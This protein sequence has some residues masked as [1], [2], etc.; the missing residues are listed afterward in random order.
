VV[1][2]QSRL[3]HQL[4]SSNSNVRHQCNKMR[5]LRLLLRQL[6]MDL[7]I[8]RFR[9]GHAGLSRIHCT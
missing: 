8:S 5:Q 4:N 2:V 9:P 7:T 6:T 1:E 3:T